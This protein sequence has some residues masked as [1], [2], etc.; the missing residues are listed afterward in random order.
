MAVINLCEISENLMG[1]FEVEI[2]ELE[3]DESL[4]T[5]EIILFTSDY[6]AF[7]IP[8]NEDRKL[9]NEICREEIGAD[10]SVFL[11]ENDDRWF[12]V[13]DEEKI[14]LTEYIRRLEDRTNA[15][16]KLL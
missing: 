5:G 14:P 4:T 7:C 3:F 12:T 11:G 10:C 6:D 15:F 8:N 13:R 16:R 1:E 2:L 9:W